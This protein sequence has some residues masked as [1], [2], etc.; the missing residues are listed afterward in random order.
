MKRVALLGDSIFDNAS[1]IPGEPPVQEQLQ[2]LLL[3]AWQVRLL[4]VDGDFTADVMHQIEELPEDTSHLVISCGG[5]DALQY[6]GI[7][8][9]GDHHNP[10]VLQ[11]ISEAR[12]EFQRDYE[13]ML[14]CITSLKRP[15]AVCTI[16]DSVPRLEAIKKTAL[17]IFNEVILR[18]AAKNKLPVIDLRIICS[19]PAD[20]SAI[21]SIEPS[22]SGGEKIAKV[23]AEILVGHD[24]SQDNCIIYS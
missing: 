2:A 3:D 16:Y 22:A 14:A 15:T 13:N 6:S 24:F 5:N 19:D 4:A 23:I 8:D 9:E 7:L 18:Q 12:A 1:Y 21:S 17:A 11:M 10:S 20:Y